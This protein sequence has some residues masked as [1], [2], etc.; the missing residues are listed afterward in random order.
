MRAA[1]CRRRRRLARGTRERLARRL[2]PSQ[3]FFRVLAIVVYEV[4]NELRHVVG[5]NDEACCLLNSCCGERAAFLQLAGRAGVS[6]RAC[7]ITTDA[8]YPVTSGALCREYMLSQSWLTTPEM[9][10]VTEG[11]DGRRYTRTLAE[12]YPHASPYTR[13]DSAEQLAFGKVAPAARA[14]MER[15]AGTP[16]GVAWRAATEAAE[17]LAA[18]GAPPRAWRRRRAG[19]RPRSRRRSRRSSTAARRTRCASSSR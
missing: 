3:S 8:P 2:T 5:H 18:A 11:G 19:R 7:Y 6:V 17:R 13:L 4:E 12:L 16:A 10:V 1:G 15:A 14:A 9:P